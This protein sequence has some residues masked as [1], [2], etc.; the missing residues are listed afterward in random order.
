MWRLGTTFDLC[1][2]SL[3]KKER[4][5]WSKEAE[6]GLFEQT[7]KL[8]IKECGLTWWRNAMACVCQHTFVPVHL[9]RHSLAL[10]YWFLDNL[11][12]TSWAFYLSL[13]AQSKGVMNRWEMTKKQQIENTQVNKLWLQHELLKLFPG[14][15][16]SFQW[17]I[18]S[19]LKY[20]NNWLIQTKQVFPIRLNDLQRISVDWGSNQSLRVFNWCAV[21]TCIKYSLQS[22]RAMRPSKASPLHLFI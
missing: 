20:N 19:H 7:C 6:T 13:M 1:L 2:S 8:K 3:N 17:Q 9:W 16:G 14:R 15:Q 11:D 10:I 5:G 21:D 22:P 18:K 4:T 12:Q